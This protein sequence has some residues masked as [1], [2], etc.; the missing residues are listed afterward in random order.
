MGPPYQRERDGMRLQFGGM[1]IVLPPDKM[2]PTKYPYAQNIRAYLR[3]RIIGRATQDSSVEVLPYAV[4]SLRRLNDLTP[5]GPPAGFILV[6]G[7]SNILY[8]NTTLVDSGLS[9]NPISLLPFRPNTSVRPWMYVGDSIKMDKVQ[10]DLTRYKM[11]I[12]EPQSAP[13]ITSTPAATTLAILGP[14][15][16]TYW[17]DSPHSG[18]TSNYIWKNATDPGGSGPIRLNTPP[19]GSTTGNSLLFDVSPTGSQAVPMEWTQYTTLVGTVNTA[20]TAVNWVSG[21][22]FT[23]L[24]AGQSIAISGVQYLILVVNSNILV[25]IS[26]SAGTQTGASYT[27]AAITGTTP[28]F[29]P[30]L[31]SEGYSDFNFCLECTLYVPAA[32]VYNLQINSKDEILWG[33]GSSPA[34]KATWPGPTGG[35]N[36]LSLMGQTKTAKNG[37]PLIRKTSIPDGA[38]QQDSALVPV[39]FPA[40]GNYPFEVDYDFWYHSGRTL[41]VIANGINIPP[42]PNSA[43][44][45]AQYRYVYRSSATGALSNPS[46]PSVASMLSVLAN[47]VVAQPSSDPQ[48]DKIDFYRLDTGLSQYT[49]VGTGPN[50]NAPFTDNLL[51]VDVAG[52]PVL[53]FDNFE[54]FPSIDLPRSGVVNVSGGVATWVS[55]DQFNIRWLPG[56]IIIVGPYSGP[57]PIGAIAYT[58][59]KRPTDTTHLTA[60]NIEIVGGIETIVPIADGTNLTYNIAEPILAAQPMPYLWGPTDNVA[61]FF[62]CGDPLRP[63]TLYWSKGNN[64]DSAPDTNQQDVTSPSEPLING[65]IVNGIGLV[66][67]SERGFLIFPNFFNALATVEGTAGATWTLQESITTRGL[68]MPRCLC[69]D[70]GGNVFF[71][72]KDG[73]YLSPGG[74]GAKSVTDEDMYNLFP[75][76][77]I[78]PEP[79]T[80]APG[81]VVYPPDDSLPQLQ[82]MNVANGY[83]YYD[84]YG[85]NGLPQTLVFDIAAGGWV[86]DSYQYPAFVHVLE[87]GPSI[88][89]V[90]IGC[91]DGSVRPLSDSGAENATSV[92]VM[93]AFNANDSRS[94]KHFAD[95]YIE[96]E[97]EET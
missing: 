40:A 55:G 15:T 21:D 34:G 66:M 16:V 22:Q 89:G 30:A 10:S 51:D 90:L 32:G 11:G 70:G 37:Y 6:A 68:Y 76:E 77:G 43:I 49:Y 85:T 19:S 1:N 33:I 53:E 4:H 31:E 42:V 17:G 81:Y 23:N 64:P 14:V 91:T 58:L 71:R 35:T 48:V 2:P 47:Q 93:P 45:E 20:G 25:T 79:I 67:S 38:G 86:K 12:A 52:N 57:G 75:H 62:G 60:S 9:G 18:P 27:A 24:S 3:E 88:N 56:T 73:I 84:Y 13:T 80:R 78:V 97:A 94:Q 7:A 83:V 44:T 29:Q 61:F 28:L 96:A 82:K 39:T 74:Q 36:A 87:E 46:P 50:S 41:K 26:T 8:G 69:V 63:G 95:I 59:D 65:C 72:A 92:V 54:P 5:A